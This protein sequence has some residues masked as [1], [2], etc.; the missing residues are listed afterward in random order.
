MG[1]S[2]FLDYDLTPD[3]LKRF[4]DLKRLVAHVINTYGLWMTLEAM[5]AHLQELTSK[6]RKPYETLYLENLTKTLDD[7]Q[8]RYQD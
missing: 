6:A 1:H 4:D 8:N 5:I 2:R 7:Y 3:Q